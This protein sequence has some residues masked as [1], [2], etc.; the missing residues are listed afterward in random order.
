MPRSI[1]TAW[2]TQMQKVHGTQP[3]VWL[4]EITADTSETARPTFRLTPYPSEITFNDGSGARVFYPSSMTQGL[5]VESGDGDLPQLDLAID[6]TRRTMLYY[7]E[8]GAGFMNQAATGWLVN[9]ADLSEFRRF[10]Y[11]IRGA[12]VSME[13][14]QLHL[15]QPNY[16]KRLVPQDRYNPSRCRWRFGGDECGYRSTSF[17]AYTECDKTIQACMLRG[18]DMVSR[19]LPKLQPERFGGFLGIPES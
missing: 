11:Q 2:R 14:A 4:W 18:L 7:F 10:D 5:I 15:E 17:A 13:A 12:S 16:F 19:N 6:N 8:T 1:P 3:W 9:L